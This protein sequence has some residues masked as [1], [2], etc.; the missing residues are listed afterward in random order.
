MDFMADAE[1]AAREQAAQA[2]ATRKAKQAEKE[3]AKKDR[4]KEEA[5]QRAAAKA[6]AR[7]A[8]KAR[9]AEDQQRQAKEAERDRKEEIKF[10]KQ[11][12]A[13]AQARQAREEME[14]AEA[15]ALEKARAAAEERR[16]A[17]AQARENVERQK[18]E[19]KAE[20][21]RVAEA[22]RR[23]AA[24]KKEA[25]AA[26][27]AALKKKRDEEEAMKIE[28]YDTDG[29]VLRR[30]GRYTVQEENGYLRK[31]ACDV[32][33]QLKAGTF[34]WDST[35]E[36]PFR[37]CARCLV[38]GDVIDLTDD[39]EFGAVGAAVGDV[40]AADAEDSD[41]EPRDPAA[42][43]P[44]VARKVA[45]A[46]AVFAAEKT[47][48][49]ELAKTSMSAVRAEEHERAEGPADT[50]TLMTVYI[51][52][53]RWEGGGIGDGG[54]WV[55]DERFAVKV[56]RSA[57]WAEL[58]TAVAASDEAA[59]YTVTGGELDGAA[60]VPLDAAHPE[61]AAINFFTVS[62]LPSR[63]KPQRQSLKRGAA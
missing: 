54:K 16:Q 13:A 35:E 24:E 30:L 22:A 21:L 7:Q 28:M 27:R 48:P 46:R 47:D 63:L 17:Q 56:P 8:A 53:G 14:A 52:P 57:T 20:R 33:L 49:A 44:D 31:W 2:A 18:A 40:K 11:R 15:A 3:Q 9:A 1:A 43:P 4:Q 10:Q 45:A 37:A 58:V 39:L 6:Q 59:A 62:A 25:E 36:D 34:Y 23:E 50:E 26:A 38:D 19:A 5:K 32:C 29:R 60:E 42:M 12:E 61:L 51:R 41:E 55:Q